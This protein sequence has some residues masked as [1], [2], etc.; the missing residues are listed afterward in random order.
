MK[1]IKHIF[2]LWLISSLTFS[3]HAITM[4]VASTATLAST[5]LSAVTSYGT[6]QKCGVY[7]PEM[8]ETMHVALTAGLA[9]ANGAGT[10][11][12]LYQ[13]TPQGRMREANRELNK[14]S[15]DLFLDS[16]KK[17]EMPVEEFE[18][19]ILRRAER[20]NAH[21]PFPLVQT[22]A[23]FE[24]YDED[25]KK[26]SALLK[27]IH[28]DIRPGDDALLEQY[29]QLS[30]RKEEVSNIVRDLLVKIKN[31]P[32]YAK[33]LRYGHE[34]DS[35][36]HQAVAEDKKAAAQEKIARAGWASVAVSAVGVAAQGVIAVAKVAKSAIGTF[37]PF[38]K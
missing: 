15:S 32:E 31:R 34:K 7:L 4:R 25:M 37:N 23:N 5:V 33:H 21:T 30:D 14:M 29:T 10:F 36:D 28:L 9:S 1:F 8:T 13:K 19:D 6:I 17:D 18:A 24:K 12:W 27:K 22:A 11:W 3:T 16:V 20:R 26:I 38:N 2:A 35:Q